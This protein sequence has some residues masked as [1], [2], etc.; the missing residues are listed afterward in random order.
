MRSGTAVVLLALLA[1]GLAPVRAAG[2]V[3]ET[4]TWVDGAIGGGLGVAAGAAL[5]LS[6]VVARAQLGEE[7]LDSAGDLI[8]WQ[9]VPMVAGPATGVV[10][11]LAGEEVL[12]GSLIGSLFG[13][14]G[15]TAIGAGVGWLASAQPESPWAGGVIG[16]GTGLSLGGFVGGLLAWRGRDEAG[17]SDPV[18]AMSIGVRVPFGGV[19]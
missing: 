10:F 2:Q 9:T 16:A 4:T 19:R 14:V 11:G 5:T 18:P 13:L 6:I 8:H 7:Y 1:G 17:G 3:D 15:G 12:V